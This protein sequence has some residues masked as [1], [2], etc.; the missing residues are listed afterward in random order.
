MR[1]TTCKSC[2]RSLPSVVLPLPPPSDSS[3]RAWAR[4]SARICCSLQHEVSANS[5]TSCLKPARSLT[6]V[7]AASLMEPVNAASRTRSLFASEAS[8]AALRPCS[9]CSDS[10]ASCFRNWPATWE[11]SSE[12]AGATASVRR[13][14]FRLPR[15][16]MMP[17]AVSLVASSKALSRAC[18]AAVLWLAS[19]CSASRALCRWSSPRTSAMSAADL[20]LV[21]PCFVA[22]SIRP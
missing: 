6:R 2:C 14:C 18:S 15:S 4:A 16:L 11:K 22:C 7:L 1:C 3:A 17:P 19:T 9:A 21:A 5:L 10:S 8:A 20:S 12:P 13:S